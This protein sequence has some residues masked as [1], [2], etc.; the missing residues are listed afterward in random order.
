[1]NSNVLEIRQLTRLARS[2]CVL[3]ALTLM[4]RAGLKRNTVPLQWHIR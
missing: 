3:S 4:S 2:K 1:M